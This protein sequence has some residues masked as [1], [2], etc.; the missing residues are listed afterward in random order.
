MRRILTLFIGFIFYYSKVELKV[1]KSDCNSEY[2]LME[3][4]FD[5]STFINEI[6]TRTDTV[7]KDA[8]LN[9][10]KSTIKEIDLPADVKVKLMDDKFLS[11]KIEKHMKIEKIEDKKTETI[12]NYD[13]KK[14]I[15]NWE[16]FYH[17]FPE[18]SQN[19]RAWK[20]RF[21][22]EAKKNWGKFNGC[23]NPSKLV[24]WLVPDIDDIKNSSKQRDDTEKLFKVHTD[25]FD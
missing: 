9:S 25:I 6:K 21:K 24:D 2:C 22:A 20:S 1:E 13:G 15:N 16:E 11:E 18:Y 12:T 19:I 3:T 5:P 8:L 14:R 17:Y 10:V 4:A 23:A 7:L